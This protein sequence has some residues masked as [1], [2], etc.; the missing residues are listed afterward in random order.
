MARVLIV[1]DDL[2]DRTILGRIVEGAGHKV[3][4]AGGGEQAFHVYMGTII[5][6]G[7]S[8]D[9][10]ITDL[11]MPGIDGLAVIEALQPLF[12]DV[13]I[14]A[15]SGKGPELLAAAKD[16]GALVALSKPV[17][18]QELLEAIAHAV[19]SGWTGP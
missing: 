16:K 19:G 11:Q 12:P 4:F 1:D 3:Y 7:T 18:P 10:I 9:V 15:V 14:I 8:I 17:D 6:M 13:A 2:I 5:D